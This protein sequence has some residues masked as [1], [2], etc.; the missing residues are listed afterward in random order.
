VELDEIREDLSVFSFYD[1]SMVMIS[2]RAQ[3]FTIF[4]AISMRQAA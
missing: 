2:G 4:R 3:A 1:G